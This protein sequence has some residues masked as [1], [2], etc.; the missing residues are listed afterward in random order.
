MI[1]TKEVLDSMTTKERNMVEQVAA[2]ELPFTE[3]QKE[4][5]QFQQYILLYMVKQLRYEHDKLDIDYLIKESIGEYEIDIYKTLPCL[6]TGA[7]SWGFTVWYI[8]Q[9]DNIIVRTRLTKDSQYGHIDTA[10]EYAQMQIKRHRA[11]DKI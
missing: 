4:H 9:K 10:K 5:N 6:V 3:L 8:E 7:E 11:G 1:S 2:R